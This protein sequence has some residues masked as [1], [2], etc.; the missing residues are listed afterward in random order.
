MVSRNNSQLSNSSRSQH[1]TGKSSTPVNIRASPCR[2][3]VQSRKCDSANTSNRNHV[4]L[5][6]AKPI[7]KVH[8]DLSTRLVASSKSDN[9]MLQDS[10][11]CSDLPSAKKKL[12]FSNQ[13]ECSG[14]STPPSRPKPILKHSRSITFNSPCQ[15]KI[16][17]R[18]NSKIQRYN[19]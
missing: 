10:L 2:N 17:V 8:G 13:L 15:S 7:L 6:V 5:P 12:S 1:N 4:Q 9:S 3:Q 16:L 19:L 11:A 14:D 18:A